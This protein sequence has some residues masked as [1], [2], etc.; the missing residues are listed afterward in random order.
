MSD[1]RHFLTLLDFSPQE[2]QQ[3][4]LRSIEMKQAYRAGKTSVRSRVAY[5]HVFC[6]IINTHPGIL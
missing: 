5:W 3:L 1:I 6:Q 4:I 2:L